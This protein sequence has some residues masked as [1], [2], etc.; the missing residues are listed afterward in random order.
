MSQG[1]KPVLV[2]GPP[3]RPPRVPA[4]YKRRRKRNNEI[5]QVLIRNGVITPEQLRQALRIQS[6]S[7]G[8]VGAI[9]RRMGACDSRAIADALIEQVRVARSSGTGM[10][11]RARQNPS[12]VGLNV[13][14]RPGLSRA[15]LILTDVLTLSLAAGI[16]G[17]IVASDTLTRA[18]QFSVIA[19]V[20]MCIAALTA[21]QMYGLTPPSPSEEIRR[22]TLTIS[23]IYAGSWAIAVSRHDAFQTM[24][25][26]AWLVGWLI[27][28]LLV[29]VGRGVLR[30]EFAKRPWWGQPVVVFGAGKVG[31]AV[32]STLQHRPQLGLK[33]V[34]I[35]DDDPSKHGTVRAT[36]GEEDLMVQSVRQGPESSHARN[37]DFETPSQRHVLEQFAE[38]EGVPIVGG[39]ELAPILAQ[40]LGIRSAVIA[41]PKLD[42]ATLLG[43][44]ERY[45]EGYSSV[46]V[47]PDLFNVAHF[48]T[49]THSLGGVLGIEV[50]R[51]LLL[52]GPRLAKRLMDVVLTTIGGLLIM[53]FVLVMAILIKLDSSGPIFY[54]QK[55]LGQD[56]VRF[57]AFKFRTMYGDGEKRL[58]EVLASN[59]EMRAEYEEFHKLTVDP[60]VTRIGRVLR[61]YSL[62]E[63]PQIWSVFVGDMSLVGPRPYLEREIPEMNG[64][65]AVILRVKPGLTGIWQVT[66]R[67]A[68]TFE[69]RV[70]L[71]VEYVRSWSPW[72]DLYV[73]ARTLPVVLGGTGS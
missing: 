63:L 53:P 1:A 69:Q 40:R 27:S 30:S 16:V 64:Q 9:L 32:V 70:T 18:Q 43:V 19:L 24:P 55:R 31:R 44:I 42:S 13:V 50:R 37:D 51:Q 72:L 57:V 22:C 23:L 10:A 20:P 25:H 45:A 14:C 26:L 5:G 21:V 28:A 49:P 3:G 34:A 36:W 2:A 65:E 41:M 38:V 29:P 73:L 62:D 61:K 71:D 4:F 33:P 35:L 59:P 6:E 17:A 66:E 48:G 54:K 46:L 60:R 68:S 67:N 7:G 11:H 15:L 39:L 52:A 12:I 56:G 58:L 47:I 8:H